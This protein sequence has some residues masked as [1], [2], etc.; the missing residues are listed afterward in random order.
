VSSLNLQ[1]N[2]HGGRTNKI[3]GLPYRKFVGATQK[4]KNKQ[5]TKSKTNELA[6]NTPPIP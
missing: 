3:M 2:T 6:S 1:P 5:A 4:N